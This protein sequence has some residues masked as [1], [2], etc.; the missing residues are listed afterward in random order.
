MNLTIEAEMEEDG[1]SLAEV[2]QLPGALAYGATRNEAM[3]RAQILAWWV[4]A[5]RLEHDEAPPAAQQLRWAAE[6]TPLRDSRWRSGDLTFL[7]A[8]RTCSNEQ[9]RRHSSR[10]TKPKLA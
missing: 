4:I 8:Y 2:P 9:H 5:E 3:S 7:L 1:R 6:A 10:P